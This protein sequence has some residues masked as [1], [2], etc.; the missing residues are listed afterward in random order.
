[1]TLI[2]DDAGANADD[3]GAGESLQLVDCCTVVFTVEVRLVSF[4]LCLSR[5]YCRPSE[6]CTELYKYTKDE[7][8]HLQKDRM[9][10][11]SKQAS[12]GLVVLTAFDC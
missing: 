9:I 6:A 12:F 7:I 1:M 10:S 11:N 4:L 2:L 3:G 8:L 5:C